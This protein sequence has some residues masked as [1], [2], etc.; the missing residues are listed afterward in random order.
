MAERRVARWVA[1]ILVVSGCVLDVPR[2]SDLLPVGTPFVVKGTAAVVD[3]NGPC[4]V[5][6]GNNGVT[7]HLFQDPSVDNQAFDRVTTPGVTSRLELAV[8][9]DLEVA[10][11]MGT[12]A[13][14][15]DILEIE[16]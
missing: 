6:Y 7:Y 4:L 10:C 13:E 14:V 5:W 3:N 11:R 16:E 9:T 8:R 1:T 2:A 15:V 12:I